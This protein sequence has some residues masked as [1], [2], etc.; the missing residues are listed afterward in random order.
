MEDFESRVVEHGNGGWTLWVQQP[1]SGP[2][3]VLE[4]Y[5]RNLPDGR[6]V[7]GRETNA[8]LSLHLED[9][10]D[11]S[12][13]EIYLDGHAQNAKRIRFPFSHS[14]EVVRFFKRVVSPGMMGIDAAD[15]FSVLPMTDGMGLIAECPRPRGRGDLDDVQEILAGQVSEH[16]PASLA[17]VVLPVDDTVTPGTVDVVAQ[18][19]SRNIPRESAL[20]LAA[21]LAVADREPMRTGVF[22]S[23]L[24]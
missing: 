17:M 1:G 18:A 13:A 9:D 7:M 24:G 15:V 8:A 2:F 4:G 23:S 3:A 14:S 22:W 19:V 6:G 21:P 5:P 10:K 11:G 20:V 12:V 16:G